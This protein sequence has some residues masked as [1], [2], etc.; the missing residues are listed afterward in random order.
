MESEVLLKLEKRTRAH[1][2]LQLGARRPLPKLGI[3]AEVTERCYI[4]CASY[5]HPKIIACI[6]SIADCLLISLSQRLATAGRTHDA[7]GRQHFSPATPAKEIIEGAGATPGHAPQ[8]LPSHE[9]AL[10]HEK[11]DIGERPVP[12]LATLCEPHPQHLN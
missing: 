8:K 11:R 9:V 10:G 2:F 3:V 4:R 5:V 1:G 7:M 12:A 6:N